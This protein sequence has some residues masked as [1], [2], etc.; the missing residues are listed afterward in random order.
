MNSEEIIDTGTDQEEMSYFI[1]DE[2]TDFSIREN[3]L[4]LELD[5]A[6]VVLEFITADIVRV[7]MNRGDTINL[8][9]TVAVV[10]HEQQYQNF[11]VIE[12]ATKLEVKT[13]KLDIIVNKEE[14]SLSFYD[15]EGN[16]LH[17]D[18]SK[19]SLGWSNDRVRAWKELKEKE[20]FYGLGEKT[21]WLDKRG[22]EY[23]MWNT[24]TFAPHVESTDPLYQSIPFLISFDVGETYGI[25]FDNTYKSHFD[26]GSKGKDFYSFGAEGG[27][28][29][30]Y[31]IN[32]ATIKDVISNYTS[33]TG[34]MPLPPKWSL[35]YH[36][37]RY[38][39]HPQ[40]DVQE[41][42]TTFREEEIPCDVIH[43][44]IHY[45]DGHRV[46]TWNDSEFPN[47]EKM[48]EDLGEQGFKVVTIIDPGVKKDP[49]YKVYQEGIA[50]D[51]F[52]KY[53]EGDLF[54]GK[55]WPGKCAFPDFTNQEVRDW[56]GD[57]HQ[58]YIEQGVKGIWNDMNEPAVF[59]TEDFTMDLDVYHE[60]DGDPG[61]QRR[62]H[63]L[64]GFLEDKA[65]YEGLKRNRP[66]ERPFVLTRAGFAGIQRYSAVWTGD[67]RSF[68][69]HLKLAMPML[70]NLGLSGVTF[71]GTD[72]GGF[73]DDADG[74]LLV[75]W[76][77]L[78]TFM[79]FFRNHSAVNCIRQEPWK[80]GAEYNQII[81]DYIKL[82]Y[83]LLPYLYNL[84]YGASQTGVP[85]LRPLVMEYP[86][87]EKTY[88]LSDQ[89]MVG[90]E[91]LVAPVYQPAR[92]ER[93]VYLPQG[94][95]Y[96][97][98]SGEKHEGGHSI[99]A[100]APVDKLPLF[101]KA[102]SIIPQIEVLNYVD[103]REVKELEL[104][105][106]LAD[107]V[108]EN[109]YSFYQDDGQSFAYQDGEYNLTEFS[110][111]YDL[112]SLEFVIDHQQQGYQGEYQNYKICFKNLSGQPDQVVVG[113]SVVTDWIYD[114][115][116][117]ELSIATTVKEIKLEF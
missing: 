52:C 98:W 30:Y 33:L 87:D 105:I 107:S 29:D 10:D 3:Y 22:R 115:Q 24:D 81:K 46:F 37:S 49:N 73:A 1:L 59:E 25:Y 23:T 80:F 14:F 4:I 82:R 96:D 68:W 58:G 114:N 99:I 111:E 35:G 20:K 66:G 84:F 5:G 63:N 60:N 57:L 116:E 45:M 95:W 53:L 43:L 39:Y 90:E 106:Y 2:V 93:L 83:R 44:D 21:G 7:V 71:S 16:L 92:E 112:D 48:I 61:T 50:N 75:R 40:E 65:T 9:T 79:P 104:D 36:Q 11:T 56:W 64:Y 62:F 6:R 8:D 15:R 55:V 19:R 32:G 12:H 89:F 54:I 17:Q 109:K 18:Y 108:A 100:D 31:F 67:N 88:N 86:E 78:G 70:M 42:A 76:T 69:E 47:P 77:Q 27:K 72:V 94:I 34:R 97:F 51:Y 91:M 74:E 26:L 103:E 41:I 117:L 110:Y 113:G 85:V 101:I 28:M 38:S 13:A 102:G